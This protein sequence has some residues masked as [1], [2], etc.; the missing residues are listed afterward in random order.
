MASYRAWFVYVSFNLELRAMHPWHFHCEDSPTG[1]AVKI[2]CSKAV[3]TQAFNRATIRLG[4][5]G[6]SILLLQLQI[7]Q[8]QSDY[9]NVGVQKKELRQ[10][11]SIYPVIR[12]YSRKYDQVVCKLTATS[13]RLLGVRLYLSSIYVCS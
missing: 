4:V 13:V 2:W 12:V 5:L 9:L 10:N 1:I 8:V 7:Q 11:L 6:I 3:R